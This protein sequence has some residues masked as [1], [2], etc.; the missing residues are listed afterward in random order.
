M[1]GGFLMMSNKKMDDKAESKN[2]TSNHRWKKL[3]WSP[4][5]TSVTITR[6]SAGI[7]IL[8][9]STDEQKYMPI[10]CARMSTMVLDDLLDDIL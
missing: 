1:T 6:Y 2:I 3:N 10:S 4:L 8:I 7:F 9:R 5:K